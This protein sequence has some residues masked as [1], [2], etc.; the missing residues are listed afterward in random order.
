MDE[1]FSSAELL[2]EILS[3]TCIAVGSSAPSVFEFSV[4]NSRS[5]R[6]GPR[7]MAQ[8]KPRYHCTFLS[9]I[10]LRLMNLLSIELQKNDR[11]AMKWDHFFYPSTS[12]DY[13][14]NYIYSFTDPWCPSLTLSPAQ[15]NSPGD[16]QL[17]KENP[18]RFGNG[19]IIAAGQGCNSGLFSYYDER[20]EQYS[21]SYS[22]ANEQ[23]S[24]IVNV[25]YAT[26]HDRLYARTIRSHQAKPGLSKSLYRIDFF[27]FDLE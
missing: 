25:I 10:K 14:M 8:R 23:T 1:W 11:H 7:K 16:V 18:I 26:N 22:D 2:I 4:T 5:C 20:S 12:G 13:Q 27:S 3:R 15:P 19:S 9:I 6:S 21:S 17:N 24:W